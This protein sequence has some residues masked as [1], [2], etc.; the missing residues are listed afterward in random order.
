MLFQNRYLSGVK[1]ISSH[2][3][4]TGSWSLLEVLFR[5]SDENPALL[6]GVQ[7][8][9]QGFSPPIFKGKSIFEYLLKA[10]EFD[11]LLLLKVPHSIV[12]RLRDVF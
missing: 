8:R 4:K 6:K 10:R 5:I 11:L 3:G 7:L 9:S 1:Q 12:H 2:A